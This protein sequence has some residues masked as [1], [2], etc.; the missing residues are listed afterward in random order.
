MERDEEELR[1]EREIDRMED[2]SE[3]VEEDI[4][5]ARRE[6]QAKQRDPGVPGAQPDPGEDEESIPGVE[7][8]EDEV[9]DQPGP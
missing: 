2:E 3:R 7:A 8:D 6:W 4:E 1:R 5:E 9:S